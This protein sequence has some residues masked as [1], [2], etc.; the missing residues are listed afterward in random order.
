MHTGIPLKRDA[1]GT[2]VE[3]EFIP[4]DEAQGTPF[5]CC[6]FLPTTTSEETVTVPFGRKITE[7]TL[8]YVPQDRSG[9]Q[10]GFDP[11]DSVLVNAPELWLVEGKL[12]DFFERYQIVGRP[13][14]FGKPGDDVIGFQA[15]LRLVEE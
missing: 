2:W 14:P 9:G 15:T 6:L 11:E 4:D 1:G 3:G 5:D 12:V 8:L 7:P 10:V 13:Q